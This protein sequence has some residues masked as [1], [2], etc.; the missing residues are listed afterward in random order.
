M[1]PMAKA[2]RRAI[3]RAWQV[4]MRPISHASS[5]MR[6]M[7]GDR[8]SPPR[9]ASGSSTSISSRCVASPTGCRAW[10]GRSRI[11]DAGRSPDPSPRGRGAPD[12]QHHAHQLGDGLGAHLFH[13]ARAMNFNGARAHAQV[14]RDGLVLL[15]EDHEIEHFA[16]ALGERLEMRA[17]P[18]VL[19]Q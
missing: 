7:A 14:L 12:V 11:S 10:A 18:R 4:S 6:W 9:T 16:L 2:T 3:S 1:A 15:A 17:D 5:T 8:C 19:T 13:D